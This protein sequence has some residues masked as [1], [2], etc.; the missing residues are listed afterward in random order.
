MPVSAD[1]S[2]F[3]PVPGRVAEPGRL[4]RPNWVEVDVS[5][6][7]HNV[8]ALRRH[9]G[10]GVKIFATLKANGCGFGLLKAAETVDTAGADAIA[11][12]DLGDAV[13]LR[14]HGLRLPIL[15]FGGNLVTPETVAAVIRYELIAT[16][17]DPESA[18]AYARH[19]DQPVSVF[20]E[21]NS[22]GERL[23]IA[24]DDVVSLVRRLGDHSRIRI[25]GVYTHPGVPAGDGAPACVEWQYGRFVAVLQALADAGLEIPLRIAASSRIL[26]MTREMNLNGVDPGQLLFGL[27]P[28]G[29]ESPS[30]DVRPALKGL[31]SRLIHIHTLDRPAFR[32]QAPFPVRDGMRIGVIPFGFSDR[33][34]ELHCAEV[35]VRGRRG[36]LL[37]KFSAEHAKIDLTGIGDA[38]VGDEVVIIGHQGDQVV[39]V[40]DVMRRRG[41]AGA[42]V[43]QAIPPGLPRLYVGGTSD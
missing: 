22:G 1:Q 8:R 17:H 23:G 14:E 7:A 29:S 35:L 28:G 5:A 3:R 39:T 13:R 6:I 19:A 36:P 30:L 4:A 42:E 38:Q 34:G 27:H 16:V 18:A 37:G 9:V 12:V 15:L 20:V 25:E 24:P 33:L 10:P 32:D 21:V 41:V 11:L 43:T 31:K 2:H 26:L 40:E